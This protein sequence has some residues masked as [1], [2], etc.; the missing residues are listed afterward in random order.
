MPR[1][2]KVKQYVQFY[3]TCVIE[4][5]LLLPQHVEVV[6]NCAFLIIAYRRFGKNLPVLPSR[7]KNPKNL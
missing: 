2:T 6:E 5:G 1:L 4:R 3:I 7:F